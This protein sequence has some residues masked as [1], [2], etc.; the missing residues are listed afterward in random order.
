VATIALSFYPLVTKA[1]SLVV[2]MKYGMTER[3]VELRL[4]PQGGKE[5][6]EKRVERGAGK[7]AELDE[8][9]FL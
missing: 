9:L 3:A 6:L 8:L 1:V 7:G 4:G 5:K 2:Q